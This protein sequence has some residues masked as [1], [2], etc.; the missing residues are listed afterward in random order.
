MTPLIPKF[1]MQ[2]IFLV[3]VTGPETLAEPLDK[4]DHLPQ[5]WQGHED[6]MGTRPA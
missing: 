4:T 5:G 2:S 6:T 1:I 3:T